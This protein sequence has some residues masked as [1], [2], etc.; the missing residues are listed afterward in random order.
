MALSET[1]TTSKGIRTNAIVAL[2][3]AHDGGPDGRGGG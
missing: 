2:P 3:S 1:Q